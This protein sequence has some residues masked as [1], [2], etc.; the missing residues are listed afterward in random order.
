M[1]DHDI[2]HEKVMIIDG[3]QRRLSISNVLE[4]YQT[5]G[6]RVSYVTDTYQRLQDNEMTPLNADHCHEYFGPN[7]FRVMARF[8][9][10]Q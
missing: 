9:M 6:T 2:K 8:S 4:H 7:H 5:H 3:K 1:F 10:Q